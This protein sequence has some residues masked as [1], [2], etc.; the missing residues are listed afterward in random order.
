MADLLAT[1]SLDARQQ[2]YVDAIRH[3][4]R[5]LLSI[6][7]DILD[8]SRIEAGKLELERIDFALA[9]VLEQVRSLWRRRRASAG[10]ELRIEQA[11][12]APLLVRGDPTRLRR[13]WSTW[14][15]TGSSSPTRAVSR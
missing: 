3:S 4:G 8:F 14:S 2:R 6:I 11:P 13:C 7:N 1:E 12:A 9:D 15:A 5:H 10:L